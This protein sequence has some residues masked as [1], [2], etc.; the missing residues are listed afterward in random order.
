VDPVSNFFDKYPMSKKLSTLD[1]IKKQKKENS[2]KERLVRYFNLRMF[3][4]VIYELKV[5]DTYSQ[6]DVEN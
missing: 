1:M 6:Q 5:K 3:D 4:K 2:F